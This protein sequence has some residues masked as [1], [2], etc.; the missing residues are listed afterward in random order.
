[1]IKFGIIVMV[2]SLFI[3]WIA[4][5]VIELSNFQRDRRMDRHQENLVDAEIR[6]KR[7]AAQYYKAQTWRVLKQTHGDK[8]FTEEETRSIEVMGLGEY[9]S[10]ETNKED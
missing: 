6:A 4:S 2:V 9:L 8:P 7:E 1:M 5:K 10:E 3:F